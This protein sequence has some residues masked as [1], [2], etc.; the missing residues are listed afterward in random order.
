MLK[1]HR[2]SQGHHRDSAL[3]YSRNDTFS[4]LFV[5]ST[6]CT[7]VANGFRPERSMA[8]GGQAPLPEPHFS[9]PALRPEPSLPASDMQACRWV[10]FTSRHEK[11]H[12]EA[13]P[14]V[15]LK[16]RRPNMTKLPPQV[17]LQSRTQQASSRQTP[18]PKQSR[19]GRNCV[20]AQ[21]KKRR[22]TRKHPSTFA[23]ARGPHCTV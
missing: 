14:Q 15:R 12:A 16:H 9:V 4:S 11:M 21:T 18:R 17:I 23:T 7:C 13:E 10:L 22:S 6:I 20:A 8:R 3:L 1:E 2:V 19:P 5:Q